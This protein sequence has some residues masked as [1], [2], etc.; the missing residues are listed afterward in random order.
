V[1]T[2]KRDDNPLLTP[3]YLKT[4]PDGDWPDDPV[5]YLVTANGLFLCRNHEFFQSSV[6]APRWPSELAP[7]E[8]SLQLRGPKIPQRT[9]EQV[10]GFFDRVADLYGSEAVVLAVWNRHKHEIE[11]IAPPQLATISRNPWDTVS[12]IGVEYEVPPLGSEQVV[13]GDIHSHVDMAAY[14]SHVDRV[15]EQYRAGLHVV[16]GRLYRE[17]PEFHIEAVVDGARFKFAPD[18]VFAG[19]QRRRATFPEEW[20]DQIKLKVYGTTTQTFGH[21]TTKPDVASAPARH[22]DEI[23]LSPAAAPAKVPPPAAAGN[24]RGAAASK[25]LPAPNTPSTRAARDSVPGTGDADPL[26]DTVNEEESH[27]PS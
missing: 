1:T 5:F 4:E 15:D 13:L 14:A 27:D 24:G 8:S 3:L 23:S 18:T 10:V 12:P 22:D 6:P 2:T 25:S 7:Q 21:S 16:V 20:L 11:I 19:Y 9:I 17:P 26:S